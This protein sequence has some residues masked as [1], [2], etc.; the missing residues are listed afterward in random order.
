MR[1]RRQLPPPLLR[2]GR[3]LLRA[4]GV[5]S[6]VWGDGFWWYR[7]HPDAGIGLS[8]KWE[9]MIADYVLRP[10]ACFVDAGAHV[11]RWTIRASSFYRRVLSFEPDPFTNTVLRR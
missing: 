7:W 11:G 3:R 10:G 2:V 4:S 5:R 6:Y 9:R 1:P 8:E